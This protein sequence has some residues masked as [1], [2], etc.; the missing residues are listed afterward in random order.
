MV[1]RH[2]A[3]TF[4]GGWCGR[5][6]RHLK[7]RVSPRS[8]PVCERGLWL[9]LR[10]SLLL[11]WLERARCDYLRLYRCVNANTH[12]LVRALR[13]PKTS[14]RLFTIRPK[15]TYYRLVV[16]GDQRLPERPADVCQRLDLSWYLCVW[17]PARPPAPTSVRKPSSPPRSRSKRLGTARG[18]ADC[19]G[20]ATR[21]SHLE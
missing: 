8:R 15:P 16:D 13:V 12:K 1:L 4:V 19:K 9:R 21:D 20:R 18:I 2:C 5:A 6:R 7:R 17:T 10:H 14:A 3:P 11:T